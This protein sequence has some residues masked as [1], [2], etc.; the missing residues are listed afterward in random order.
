MTLGP[1]FTH[2]E[3]SGISGWVVGET[4]DGKPLGIISGAKVEF[5]DAEG[6]PT[7]STTSDA[8]G[9]YSV[10][11]L[12]TGE[13]V[14]TYRVSAE[15]FRTEDDGR[16]IQ[17]QVDGEEHVLDFVLTQG[18][19]VPKGVGKLNGHVW[20]QQGNARIPVAEVLV[21]VR[22]D[23]GGAAV[24]LKTDAEGA[25]DLDLPIG[26]Y[27]VS[28][29]AP[30]SIPM[31]HSEVKQV[32]ADK[33]VT[34]DFLMGEGSRIDLEKTVEVYALVSVQLADSDSAGGRAPEVSFE[35]LSGGQTTAA[36]VR[37]MD[38]DELASL[39]LS[40][41][42]SGLFEWYHA[43]AAQPLPVGSYVAKASLA[44][45][46]SD[47][48]DP[49]Q[50]TTTMSTTFDLALRPLKEGEVVTPSGFTIAKKDPP[51]VR[52]WVTGQTE[53]GKPLGV[54]ASAKVEFLGMDGSPAATTTTS[55][56]GFYAIEPLAAGNYTY[57]V[58]AD[59]YAPEDAGRGFTLPDDGEIHVHD[60]VRTQGEPVPTGMAEING[61]VW[62]MEGGEKRAA[63][64]AVVAL[65]TSGEAT[66][67]MLIQTDD[68]GAYEVS[69]PTGTYNASATVTG[70]PPSKHPSDIK[71]ASGDERTVDFIVGRDVTIEIEKTVEV[72]ALI[73][74]QLAESDEPGGKTPTAVFI[75]DS[76]GTSLAA[77]VRPLSEDD[78]AQLGISPS[79]TL[80]GYFEWFLAQ[81]RDPLPVGMY[82][83]AASLD[84]YHPD[85]SESKE[86]SLEFSTYY[87]LA[88]SPMGKPK[89]LPVIPSGPK[90]PPGL[91][92]W[93][94]GQND[95][96]DYLGPIHNAKVE[97][98]MAG[99]PTATATSSEI[100]YYEIPELVPGTYTY[101]VTADAF[102]PDDAGRG[103]N[104]PNDDKVHVQDFVLTQGTGEPM[105][106]A[107]LMATL[108][109]EVWWIEEDHEEPIPGA[110]VATRL[111]GDGPVVMTQTDA[112]GRYQ[113][114]LPPGQ[115]EVGAEVQGVG[116]HVHPELVQLNPGAVEVVDF[117]FSEEIM[118]PPPCETE[119]YVL[120]AVE[121]ST[122][123]PPLVEIFREVSDDEEEF[124]VANLEAL[125]PDPTQSPRLQELR[126][127]F[128]WVPEGEWRWFLG[129]SPEP[130]PEGEYAAEG[131]LDGWHPDLSDFAVVEEGLP[132][133][134]ELMLERIIPELEVVVQDKENKPVPGMTVKVI[135]KSAG[136]K[137]ADALNLTTDAQGE[138][139]TDLAGGMATYNL[140]VTGQGYEPQGRE[141][142][143]SQEITTEKFRV[144]KEGDM[145]V[146]DFPGIVVKRIEAT[147]G[148]PEDVVRVPVADAKVSLQA[149][150]GTDGDPIPSLTTNDK[151]EFLFKEL[152]EG[153]YTV[154]VAAPCC[155]NGTESVQVAFGMEPVVIELDQ[156]NQILE[157]GLRLVLNDGWGEGAVAE[158]AAERGGNRAQREAPD[159][160]RADYA[161]A[162][163][164]M[165]RE[166]IDAAR[167]HAAAAIQKTP[168][169]RFWD[170]AC[171]LRIWSHM[172]QE[173][174]NQAA[175]EIRSLVQ[176]YLGSRE[177]NPACEE[178][179]F[180]CGAAV[181]FMMGPAKEESAAVNPEA[182]DQAVEAALKEPMRSAYVRGRDLVLNDYLDI[183]DEE[184]MLAAEMFNAAASEKEAKDAERQARMA[185]IE[186]ELNALAPEIETLE[187]TLQQETINCEGQL[188]TLL[189]QQ[190]QL[191]QQIIQFTPRL[192]EQTNCLA[193]D[194]QDYTAMAAVDPAGAAA[195]LEEMRMHEREILVLN[196]QVQQLRTQAQ[197]VSIAITTMQTECRRT[198]D[199][200][201]QDITIKRQTYDR[202]YKEW[203]D[204]DVLCRNPIDPRKLE[205]PELA[206]LAHEKKTFY[207]YCGYPLEERKQ[208]M[209]ALLPCGL[210]KGTS[211]PPLPESTMF[212]E[213]V[214]P[215]SA[216]DLAEKPMTNLPPSAPVMPNNPAVP[217][218]TPKIPSRTFS[219][220]T[221][222]SASTPAASGG[223]MSSEEREVFEILN[224]LRVQSGLP[225][226][227]HDPKLTACSRD[228]SQDMQRF[229]FFDHESPVP[230]KKTPWDRAEKFDVEANAEN[231]A[232]N[233][234]GPSA[235]IG[236][237][238]NSDGHR[239]NIMNPAY[240][241]IGIGKVG[242]YWTQMFG[243]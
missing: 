183:R 134:L 145:R 15:G 40:S 222:G 243:K 71:L 95:K 226:F 187:R 46:T 104:L 91:R 135:N 184:Q 42:S 70:F 58:T 52:G 102:S 18:P 45:Y 122:G 47:V 160:C 82:H 208:E 89:P 27:R 126:F 133:F 3:P 130:V 30:E 177:P 118:E 53:S 105:P 22:N 192:N 114:L 196:R 136:H 66:G 206:D 81:A 216:A 41:Q 8:Q 199:T 223:A 137:L 151:G 25:Y 212:E 123:P 219:P 28:A 37:P 68:E 205:S 119:L 107:P 146:A 38:D 231:I 178:T 1:A 36:T 239:K 20:R 23:Q 234:R 57:R 9:Y 35:S 101:R 115:W 193:Q 32:E 31:I 167:A 138:T 26:G 140:M 165:S 92:G 85:S 90:G 87:D 228:H 21:A 210:E 55:E 124:V 172:D 169:D 195:I 189:A 62:V 180:V 56:I 78:L 235:V 127:V 96:G 97:L 29:T 88:L 84:G 149:A 213:D 10:G 142:V 214:P 93:V 240:T 11:P 220:Q 237:W 121:G 221:M 171:E 65:R 103:F 181:G 156:C 80:S 175:T 161:L 51:G 170:R 13:V 201:Q 34:V 73:S 152:P 154:A 197:Q 111:N 155:E 76:N 202:L 120:I 43:E 44:D 54:I 67:M 60:F 225:Q 79:T 182:L 200:L 194:R 229:G 236:S 98:F 174:I 153:D 99:N 74:V 211:P 128:D 39:G 191:N 204:L 227:T 131:M 83:A 173:D 144:Y 230:G 2:A 17:L 157:D 50:V 14:L 116:H 147:S 49:Q 100:G 113:F 190:Q 106:P 139:G 75:D 215:V 185:Q 166:D 109:G 158:N 64:D 132:V 19:D 112:A 110:N 238:M 33:T 108:E 168:D 203:Q 94:L 63:D 163:A 48:S 77:N 143:T 12:S 159:D 232:Q 59:G 16:G 209:L 242:E 162:L 233:G 224:E 186:P 141:V 5:L 148:K 61:H 86:V 6:T 150:A 198:V 164:A 218:L 4:E 72:Y 217:Q 7:F 125:G 188:Q 129:T 241:R 207:A 117:E 24:M 176:K 179:A 69:L